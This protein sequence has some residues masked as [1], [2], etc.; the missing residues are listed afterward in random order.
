MIAIYLWG[1][2]GRKDLYS[3]SQSTLQL[4]KKAVHAAS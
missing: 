4:S 3:A 1:L 2:F